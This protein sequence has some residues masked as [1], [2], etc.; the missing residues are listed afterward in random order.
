MMVFQVPRLKIQPGCRRGADIDIGLANREGPDVALPMPLE[1]LAK[2]SR[3]GP[4]HNQPCSRRAHW[5]SSRRPFDG[6]P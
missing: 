2:S 6:Q 1:V 5:P 4:N 3:P